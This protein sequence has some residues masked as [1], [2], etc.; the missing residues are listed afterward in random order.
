MAGAAGSRLGYSACAV[1]HTVKLVAKTHALRR[2]IIIGVLRNTPPNLIHWIRHPQS[3]V[4]GNATP[5]MGIAEADARDVAA[6]PY[7]MR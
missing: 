1:H 6:Y 4:P 5:D 2:H 3:V 7:T